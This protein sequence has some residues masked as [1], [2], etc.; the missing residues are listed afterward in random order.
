MDVHQN[1]PKEVGEIRAYVTHAHTHTH[2]KKIQLVETK[3]RQS[4]LHFHSQ[5]RNNRLNLFWQGTGVQYFEKS[6]KSKYQ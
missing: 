4:K 6:M 3:K 5:F 1:A 2:K